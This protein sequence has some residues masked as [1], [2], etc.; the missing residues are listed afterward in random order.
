MHILY[1]I[2][3]SKKICKI[4]S[5]TAAAGFN[6]R[7][8]ELPV[9][10]FGEIFP[11][12]IGWKYPGPSLALLQAGVEGSLW[13]LKI[14]MITALGWKINIYQ[15]FI[16]RK[17]ETGIS[18]HPNVTPLN[19]VSSRLDYSDWGLHIMGEMAFP[20]FYNTRYWNLIGIKLAKETWE[21]NWSVGN[22]KCTNIPW[23]FDIPTFFTQ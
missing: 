8:G 21:N 9:E 5:Q 12:L 18:H 6:Q 14:A 20:F 13:W 22:T 3:V 2:E 11:F 17:L 1:Y 23:N 15:G 4:M 10:V 16:Q 7:Q 19:Q